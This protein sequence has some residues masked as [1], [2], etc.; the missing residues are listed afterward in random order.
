LLVRQHRAHDALEFAQVTAAATL[1][2][3]WLDSLPGGLGDPS[4]QLSLRFNLAAQVARQLRELGRT[5]Q[6]QQIVETLRT[7]AATDGQR[8]TRWTALAALL[9]QLD[10]YDESFAALEQALASNVAAAPAFTQVF[11]KSGPLAAAWFIEQTS[12]DPLADRKAVI[13][14]AAWLVAPLPPAGKLPANWRSLI[15]AY[16]EQVR[17][18]PPAERGAK[19]LLPA[20]ICRIRG[21]L[22]LGGL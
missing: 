7:L 11:K 10:Q 21:D 18:L 20:E 19:L 12:R 4:Q 15:E 13:G 22:K 16:A 9:W 14:Q 6:M 2:R 8:G 5:G 1:D 17:K 3:K